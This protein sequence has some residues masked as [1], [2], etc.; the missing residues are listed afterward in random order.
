MR[1]TFY[2]VVCIHVLGL[3]ALIYL[4]HP[5]IGEFFTYLL[6]EARQSFPARKVEDEEEAEEVAMEDPSPVQQSD[7]KPKPKS[8]S[9]PLKRVTLSH[10][11]GYGEEAGIGL[12]TDYTTLGL[13]LATDYSPGSF[14][15][16]FD[17]RA[18][19]FDNDSYAVSFGVGA[20]Y[21]PR[22]NSP[23]GILGF[24]VFYD[25]R[26]GFLKQY[27]QVGVGIEVLG[28]MWDFRANAYVP[29]GATKFSTA[30]IFDDYDGGFFIEHD[31]KEITAYGY[32]A[33]IGCLAVDYKGFLFY[34]AIGPYYLTRKS[35]CINFE[36]IM[37]GR[38]RVRPQYRDYFAF[39][40]CYSYDSTFHSIFEGT[41]YVYLPLYQITHQNRRPCCFTDR[42]I[43]QPIERLDIMPLGN[44]SS[45]KHNF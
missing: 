26:Q 36:P 10:N 40:A 21:I 35:E 14:F 25:W 12:G 34:T 18:H 23:C 37:G 29:V 7:P 2:L 3:C 41:F 17:I 32:N 6:K 43:Y 16:L 44:R 38:V 42:Q 19:R 1:R 24:N 22:S 45:W 31:R 39:D 8:R 28:R 20:R 13:F 33:E 9:S 30:C 4:F 5:Y 11:V 27:N 15:P